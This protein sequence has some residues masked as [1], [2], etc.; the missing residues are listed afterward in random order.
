MGSERVDDTA[1]AEELGVVLAR[2]Y[3]FLR[4]AILPSGV[5]LP[6]ALALATLRDAGPQRVTDLAELE[7]VRQPTCTALVNAM[8]QEG[9]VSRRVDD[10]DR[11]AVVVDIT[12]EG[13]EVLLSITRARTRLFSGYLAALSTSE[14]RALAAALPALTRLIEGA[15]DSDV[16]LHPKAESA[17]SKS[18]S[19][20]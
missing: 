17:S 3:G 14:R 13:R 1:L 2:L 20:R 11:R 16:A 12:P 18:M 4:R 9:W 6:Q 8:E 15:G 7:R 19:F 5:S 10:C